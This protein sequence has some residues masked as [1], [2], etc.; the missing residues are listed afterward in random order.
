MP[1]LPA[2]CGYSLG[3]LGF[4][5]EV[6]PKLNYPAVPGRGWHLTQLVKKCWIPWDL[7]NLSLVFCQTLY[8]NAGELF[9]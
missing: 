2:L 4:G 9:T 1:H 6:I 8:M 5:L 3:P 7:G